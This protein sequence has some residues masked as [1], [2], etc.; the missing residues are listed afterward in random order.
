MTRST[1]DRLRDARLFARE[2]EYRVLGLDRD[3]FHQV[4]EVKYTVY[5]CLIGIGE[6]LKDVPEDVL[7]LEADIP[8]ASIVAMRNRLVHAYWRI[9][10][11]I[12]YD[13]ATLELPSLGVALE[14]IVK[15]LT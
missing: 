5:Y 4:G 10:D 8:W 1:I 12:V 7:T 2:G 13:V 9:D 15:R 6:A 14:A 3:V 11:D